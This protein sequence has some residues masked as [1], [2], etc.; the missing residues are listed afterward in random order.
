M[1]SCLICLEETDR[2]FISENCQC[3]I[4]GHSECIEKYFNDSDHKCMICKKSFHKSDKCTDRLFGCLST[5]DRIDCNFISFIILSFI[6]T[7][8]IIIPISIT[9]YVVNKWNKYTNSVFTKLRMY[10]IS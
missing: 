6:V 1:D 3:K 7:I 9:I 4:Y 2:F 10:K 8:V 5:L